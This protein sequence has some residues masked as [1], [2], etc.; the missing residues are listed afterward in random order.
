VVDYWLKEKPPRG[1]VQLEIFD[2][3][4]A[5]VRRFSSDDS[6]PKT[7]PKDVPIAMEWVRD[8][9][10]LSTE[11]GM[12]RF[13][14][15]LRCA[16]PKSVH[17]SMYGPADVWT[18]PGNYTVKLTAARKAQGAGNAEVS[19]GLTEI[20]RNVSELDGAAGEEEFGLLGLRLPGG[21]PATLH[22]VAAALTG[23]LMILDGTGTAPTAD[24][25]RAAEQWEAAAADAL[26]RWKV[27]EEDLAAV[28]A[29]LEKAK[30]QPLLK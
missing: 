22:K 21:E 17:R 19:A 26:A 11:A 6:L 29:V 27:V 25:Q 16:L 5:L 28:N 13:V 30:L 7:N 24:A 2:G 12:H 8:A 3:E 1:P 18:L 15:D 14:W 9:K 10:P 20:A 4:G 23:L